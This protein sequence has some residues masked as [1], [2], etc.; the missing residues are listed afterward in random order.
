MTQIGG[1]ISIGLRIASVRRTIRPDIKRVI[2][3]IEPISVNNIHD[4]ANTGGLLPGTLALRSIVKTSILEGMP[5]G[6]ICCS[7][8]LR[9]RQMI[10][11]ID[12]SRFLFASARHPHVRLVGVFTHIKRPRRR[13]GLIS[14][15]VGPCS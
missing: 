12:T 13:L 3:A 15:I 8:D 1:I 10:Y 6:M 5:L 4:L 11:R 7:R 14:D 9:P 2:K